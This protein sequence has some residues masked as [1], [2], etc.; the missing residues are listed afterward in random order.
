MY[1]YSRAYFD[2]FADGSAR[3][4][5]IVLPAVQSLLP[6][7][8]VVDFGCGTGW[9]LSTWQALGVQDIVGC[10]GQP[11]DG[12]MLQIDPSRFVT[13]DLALP[14]RLG[15]TFDLVQSLEVAEHLPAGAASTFVDTLVSH[16]P[17]V[18]FSAATPGQGGEHHVNE[19]PP[20]YWRALFRERGYHPVDALRPALAHEKTVEPWYRYNTVLYVD[21]ARVSS[22]HAALRRRVVPDGIPMSV[23]AP[24]PM[25]KCQGLLRHVPE[26]VMTRLAAASRRLLGR[27][28]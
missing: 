4:A 5:T 24:W 11:L 27:R 17:V 3:S 7:S 8:S 13:V 14:V 10:D 18:L 12:S 22:L 2:A 23:Y 16:G 15:R 28:R 1:R 6:V 19:Q 20:E 9:W 25:R 21:G 26:P